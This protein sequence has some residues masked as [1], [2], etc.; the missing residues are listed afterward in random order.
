MLLG[1]SADPMLSLVELIRSRSVIG[2]VVDS[3]GLQL[4]SLDPDYVATDLT[5]VQVQR[6]FDDITRKIRTTDFL[7]L[8]PPMLE[9]PNSSS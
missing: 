8:L 9:P 4:I 5:D 7:R 1:R 6:V 3:V 2:A